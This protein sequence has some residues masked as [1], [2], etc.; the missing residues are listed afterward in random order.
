M[1][2]NKWRASTI[3]LFSL[4]LLWSRKILNESIYCVIQEKNETVEIEMYNVK[5]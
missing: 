5:E 1:F 2:F 4:L 3:V